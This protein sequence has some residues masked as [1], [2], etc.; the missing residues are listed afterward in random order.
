MEEIII[1]AW[2]GNEMKTVVITQPNGAGGS[3]QILIDKF[4][5]GVL[6]KAQGEW[7][8]YLNSRSQLTSD[9]ISIL[10]DLAERLFNNHPD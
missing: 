3:F 9:D 1:P 7:K 8:V 5:Q 4:Y 2:Y 10:T 6:L